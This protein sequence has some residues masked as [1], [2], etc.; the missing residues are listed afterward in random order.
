MECGRL[1]VKVQ[2]QNR[3][4]LGV[5]EHVEVDAN[6]LLSEKSQRTALN[7]VALSFSLPTLTSGIDPIVAG[8]NMSKRLTPPTIT[9][10]PPPPP[11]INDRRRAAFAPK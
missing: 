10:P 2:Q 9:P 7:A 3:C 5:Q 8:L 6:S 4:G 11:T 1:T